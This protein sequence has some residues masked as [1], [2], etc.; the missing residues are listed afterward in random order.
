M[1]IRR[2][3][4]GNHAGR[5]GDACAV[6][7]VLYEKR[8][9]IAVISLNR[10]ETL[11]AYNVAMRDALYE[12]LLAIRDDAEVRAVVLRGN[13]PAFSSGG[14]V[15]EF[16]S[17]PSPLG[18]RQARW[19]RDVWGTLRALRQPTIAAVHGW[20][21]GGGW[22]MALLCDLCLAGD[23]ARFGLP[24]TALAMIPGVAGTQTLPR[25]VGL[26]RAL[27]FVLTG[28]WLTAA[29][30]F[31]LGIAV[32]VVPRA[33]L[34]DE[35]LAEARRL[36]AME[37]ELLRACKRAV[38]EGLDLPLVVGLALERRLRPA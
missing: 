33:R 8:G 16:G 21:A 4:G 15:R 27:D 23:D 13:G 19:A 24:E 25:A 11:N 32:R 18:A 37:P 6:P 1:K 12:I 9:G 7:P 30:A 31:D 2:G 14:D 3:A 36:A 26:G 22:E 34:D 38:W 35:A 5:A 29:E 17:A 20:A 28:R 10:P